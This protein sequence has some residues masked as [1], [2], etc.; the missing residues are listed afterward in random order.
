[1]KQTNSPVMFASKQ[2][3][4]M[5]TK[6]AACE[7]ENKKIKT[8]NV[9]LRKALESVDCSLKSFKKFYNDLEQYGRRDCVE[10]CGVPQPP[11]DHSVEESTNDIAKK[12]GNLIGVKIED[13]DIS[14]SH[15][16]PNTKS[17]VSKFKKLGPAAIIVKFMRRDKKD[18][19]Y[20]ARTKLK[21]VTRDL[22]FPSNN[23][24]FINESLTA[25]N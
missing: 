12:V 2:Y 20:R 8:K 3:D 10:I 25:E 18:E 22:G 16:I 9:V 5:L 4:D 6:V 11:P 7:E 1:M 19:F 14:I 15:R 23:H 24:I 21:K 13:R 17:R